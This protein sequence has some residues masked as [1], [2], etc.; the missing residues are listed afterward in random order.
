M[1]FVVQMAEQSGV[2]CHCSSGDGPGRLRMVL[3][4]HC[5][6]MAHDGHRVGQ[7]WSGEVLVRE[8]P[9]GDRQPSIS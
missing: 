6:E 7:P 4:L 3:G 9:T 1:P 2:G 8:S 5:E